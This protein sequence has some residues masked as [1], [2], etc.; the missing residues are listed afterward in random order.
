M[1]NFAI[2]SVAVLMLY[3]PYIWCKIR[4][5]D[6][7]VY[8]LDW[9]VGKSALRFTLLTSAVVLLVLTPVA[10]CWPNTMLPHK[11]TTAAALNMIAAGLAAAVIEETFYRGW[12]ET[13]LKRKMNIYAAI[14]IVN[15]LFAS[16]H[17][18]LAPNNLWLLATFFPGLIMSFLREKYGNILPSIIFHFLG[19]LWAV[20]FFPL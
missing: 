6:S 11:R 17:L 18:V 8:G 19:N 16:S 2:S 13:L 14:V 7:S 10:L 5:E 15:I 4:H 9:K 20:W 12:L 1:R 3:F